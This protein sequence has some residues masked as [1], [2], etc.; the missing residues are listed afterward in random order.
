MGVLCSDLLVLGG[1][2]VMQL[3]HGV[4]QMLVVFDVK[5]DLKHV[6]RRIAE[7]DARAQFGQQVERVAVLEQKMCLSECCLLKLIVW[8]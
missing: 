7:H 4:S 8:R 1:R 6:A 2:D 3:L 5:V